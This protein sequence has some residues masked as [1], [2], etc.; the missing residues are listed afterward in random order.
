MTQPTRRHWLLGAAAAATTATLPAQAQQA[1]S[2][3]SPLGTDVPMVFPRTEFVYESIVDI[4]DMVNMGTGPLGERRIV[5][6]TGGEFAGP[7]IKGVVLPGGADRQLVRQD[8]ARLLDAL[9]EL[10]TD[11]GVV[12]TVHNQ[13]LV[14]TPQGEPRY[15]ASHI[16]LSAP[17]GKYGWLNDCVYTGTLDSL[18]PKRNAVL[19]RVFRII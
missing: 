14:R 2:P 16:R 9:Y 4:A 3:A 7:G 5:P 8:G 1:P 10:K 15:A 6:I 17:N 12:V 11:D 19:I 18:R 13:V